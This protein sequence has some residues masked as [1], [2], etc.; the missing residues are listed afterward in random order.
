MLMLSLLGFSAFSLPRGDLSD[1]LNIVLTLLLTTT[2]FKFVVSDTIPK[3]GYN[4][5]LD[6]F[7]LLNM[8]FL[9]SIACVC[10]A[11][12]M[13]AVSALGVLF[14]AVNVG[15]G[16]RVAR[17]TRGSTVAVALVVCCALQTRNGT[18]TAV[19]SPI[20]RGSTRGENA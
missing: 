18:G 20:R 9:F 4:T 11:Q 3:V 19:L 17:C 8:A 7:I 14:C 13:G 15:W 2:A 12:D 5:H 10:V 1:R 16:V 6:V